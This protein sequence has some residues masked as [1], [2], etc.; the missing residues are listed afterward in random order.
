MDDLGQELRDTGRQILAEGDREDVLDLMKFRQD[1]V[2]GERI[3]KKVM[4]WQQN[5]NWPRASMN[6]NGTIEVYEGSEIVCKAHARQRK[7]PGSPRQTSPNFETAYE[8]EDECS[9]FHKEF[10]RY[11]AERRNLE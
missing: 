7:Q 4:G 3:G 8:F 9:D 11:E 1:P 2:L 6:D 10:V 5:G